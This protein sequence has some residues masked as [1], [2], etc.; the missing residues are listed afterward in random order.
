MRIEIEGI[1]AASVEMASS[2]A[3]VYDIEQDLVPTGPVGPQ[4]ENADIEVPG[5]DGQLVFN[6]GGDLGASSGLTY[7][8]TLT[9]QGDGT[10]LDL[11]DSG[12]NSGLTYDGQTLKVRPENTGRQ[13][14]VENSQGQDVFYTESTFD[15]LAAPRLRGRLYDDTGSIAVQLGFG[16]GLNKSVVVGY[17]GEGFTALPNYAGR[18]VMGGTSQVDGFLFDARSGDMIFNA[19]GTNRKAVLDNGLVLNVSTGQ[20]D[21]II[22]INDETGSP[23]IQ[24]TA[25]GDREYKTPGKGIILTSEDG[26][27]TK[28]V[29]LDNNGT[30]QTEAV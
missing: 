6:D 22:Q 2:E 17:Y 20:T 10:L 7:D 16:D 23:L 24:E 21:P 28:R 8:G 25:S 3:S 11:K 15:G 1:G 4:G 29:Y 13:L 12:G 18:A 27:H 19:A 26:S 14:T 9:V 5:Q 30:L